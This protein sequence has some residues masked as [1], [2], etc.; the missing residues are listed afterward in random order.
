MSQGVLTSA[1]K[2]EISGGTMVKMAES[3]CQD[4]S[5]CQVQGT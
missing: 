4:A 3:G 5:L 2:C 1:C